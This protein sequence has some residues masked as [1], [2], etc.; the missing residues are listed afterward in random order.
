METR[1]LYLVLTGPSFAVCTNTFGA[2]NRTKSSRQCTGARNEKKS[3]KSNYWRSVFSISCL[4]PCFIVPFC[5]HS[6]RSVL[7]GHSDT[8]YIIFQDKRNNPCAL[9]FFLKLA[10]NFAEQRRT[11]NIMNTW[12]RLPSPCRTPFVL[13][14]LALLNLLKG[15]V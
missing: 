1:P 2:P 12:W 10:N 8:K 15:K 11:G 7:P 4:W 14:T 13:L 9:I 6:A 5:G 3:A